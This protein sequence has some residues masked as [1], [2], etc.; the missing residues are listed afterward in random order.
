MQPLKT[1]PRAINHTWTQGLPQH[2]LKH[3]YELI[4]NNGE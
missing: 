2:S 1:R 4:S 3:Y